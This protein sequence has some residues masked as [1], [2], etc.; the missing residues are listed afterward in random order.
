MSYYDSENQM[1][2]EPELH[3]YSNPQHAIPPREIPPASPQAIPVAFGNKMPQGPS[4]PAMRTSLPPTPPPQAPGS[5]PPERKRGS[6]MNVVLIILLVGLALV[7]ILGGVGGFFLYSNWQ[8]SNRLH[9]ASTATAQT[10]ATST[11]QIKA[12]ASAQA[13]ATANTF[14]TA[15]AVVSQYPFSNKLVLD[16]PLTDNSKGSG[17]EEGTFANGS[18]VCQFKGGAYH[19]G[20]SRSGGYINLC[21]AQNPSFRD[22]TYEVQVNIIKGNAGG[23]VFDYYPFDPAYFSFVVTTT[24]AYYLTHRVKGNTTI[25]STGSSTAIKQGLNQPNVIGVVARENSIELYAN[26]HLLNHFQNTK[27]GWVI[28]LVAVALEN[29]TE[30]AFSN[31]KVWE[32][33][34]GT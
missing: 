2:G 9:A 5:F 10:H 27:S 6:A 3:E 33:P 22:Y 20:E 11:A 24:G 15:T 28:G 7:L 17:W 13:K 14:A 29:P 19:V 12:T 31:V 25:L 34:A 18:Q 32:L 30:V 8:T 4:M 16:D 26:G 21:M 23:V 1:P